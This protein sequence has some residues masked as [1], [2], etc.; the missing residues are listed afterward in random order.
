MTDLTYIV[1]W[2]D[3]DTYPMVREFAN[4]DTAIS[5]FFYMVKLGGNAFIIVYTVRGSDGRF[6]FEREF[7]AR[8]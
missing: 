1:S 7:K 8:I 5:E 2:R 6:I 4:R 3:G